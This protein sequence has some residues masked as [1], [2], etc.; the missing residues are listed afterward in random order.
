MRLFH[1]KVRAN[2]TE[3]HEYYGKVNHATLFGAAIGLD[4]ESAFKRFSDKLNRYGWTMIDTPEVTE[5]LSG[6][7]YDIDP[8]DAKLLDNA[9]HFGADFEVIAAASQERPNNI[10]EIVHQKPVT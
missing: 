10:V 1:Y 7:E 4:E 8:R 3:K 9:Q 6:V 2:P 5:L